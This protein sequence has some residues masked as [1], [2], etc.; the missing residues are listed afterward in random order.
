MIQIITDSCADLSQQ[1][2]IAINVR[3]IPLHVLVDSKDYHDNE[4]TL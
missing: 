4:L 1:L 3:F 2:L